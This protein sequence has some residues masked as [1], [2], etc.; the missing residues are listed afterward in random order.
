[1]IVDDDTPSDLDRRLRPVQATRDGRR[2]HEHA[3]R[4]IGRPAV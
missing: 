3:L 4:L 1:M 2:L